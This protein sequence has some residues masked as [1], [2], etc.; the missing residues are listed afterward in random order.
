MNRNKIIVRYVFPA[1][2]ERG[3]DWCA[4]RDGTEEAGPYGHGETEEDAVR[5][6]IEQEEDMEEDNQ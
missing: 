4:F 1:I 6:L 5:D 2:P 3:F